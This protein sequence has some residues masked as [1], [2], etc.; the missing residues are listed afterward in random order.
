MRRLATHRVSIK[1]LSFAIWH[2]LTINSVVYWVRN[3]NA[4]NG[5][6]LIFLIL[7]AMG[8]VDSQC[9]NQQ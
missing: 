6:R 5:K 9:R 2:K 3:G 8:N 7:T 1:L 4:H